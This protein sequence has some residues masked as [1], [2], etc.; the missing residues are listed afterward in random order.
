MKNLKSLLPAILLLIAGC[1][2]NSN[3]TSVPDSFA[4]PPP[5]PEVTFTFEITAVNITN[6]QPFS[7]LAVILH[8]LDFSSFTVGESAS[9]EL[10]MLSESGDNSALLAMADAQES[11]FSTASG[12]GILMPGMNETISVS[13]TGVAPLDLRLTVLSMPV[14]TNDA[15]TGGNGINLNDLEVGES[16]MFTSVAYDA[17][18]EANTE[19]VTD[20]PG[21]VAG[22]EGF[23]AIRD[24]RQNVVTMHAGVLTSDDGLIGSVLS[25]Q[26]R[27]LNPVG[28]FHILRTE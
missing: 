8:T 2:G 3:N 9:T 12:A 28:S 17:G 19:S 18:T 21:P 22:G 15:F 16:L 1:G 26:H 6:A 23:N 25:S 20:I 24:D 10:E 27:F 4:T 5:P 14:N 13:T 11:V 7:P